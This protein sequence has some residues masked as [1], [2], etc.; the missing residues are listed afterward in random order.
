[1]RG[2]LIAGSSAAL[3][4]SAHALAD[5]GVPDAP[6]T[7]LL[8]VMIGWTATALAANASAI[9]SHGSTVVDNVI[10]TMADISKSSAKIADIARRG[11]RAARRPRT[12]PVS[13]LSAP[14]AVRPE[15]D[16]T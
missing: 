12:A 13:L 16:G 9:A 5:G 2:A 7:L 3:A 1:M 8:T 10:S 6:L 11:L 14:P 15:W 4:V